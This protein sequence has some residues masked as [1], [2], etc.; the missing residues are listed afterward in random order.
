M[1]SIFYRKKDSK[2]KWHYDNTVTLLRKTVK[3]QINE[4]KIFPYVE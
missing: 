3:T 2:R 4:K 1:N